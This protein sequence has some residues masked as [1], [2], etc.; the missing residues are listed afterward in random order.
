MP[1]ER[2]KELCKRL[3]INFRKETDAYF[4]EWAM[5]V[6]ESPFATCRARYAQ[7]AGAC[8]FSSLF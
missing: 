3:G 6:S 4:G 7:E 1:Y 5:W 8:W 2:R